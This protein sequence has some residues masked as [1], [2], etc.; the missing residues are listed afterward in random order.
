MGQGLR[1][2][3]VDCVGVGQGLRQGGV[4]APLLFNMFFTVVL[5]VAVERLSA[6]ANVVEDMVCTKVR[7]AKWGGWGDGG[8]RVGEINPRRLWRSRNRSGECCTQTTR[9]SFPDR[10]TALRR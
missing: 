8:R 7:F 4:L 2:G 9:A 6:D 10:E 5:R 1:Q 3:G